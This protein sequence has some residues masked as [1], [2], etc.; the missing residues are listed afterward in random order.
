[1]KY[2]NTRCHILNMNKVGKLLT[3]MSIFANHASPYLEQQVTKIMMKY[4]IVIYIWWYNE[5]T[6]WNILID[7][8]TS[9][10]VQR[11]ALITIFKNQE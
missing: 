9:S 7:L 11:H 3:K 5:Q 8:M 10:K 6:G 1:M 2:W 4:K